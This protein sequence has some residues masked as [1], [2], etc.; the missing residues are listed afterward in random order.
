MQKQSDK[1]LKIHSM[2]ID[3]PKGTYKNENQAK[4]KR[5]KDIKTNPL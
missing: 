2:I 4:Y 5:K 3:M 1:E